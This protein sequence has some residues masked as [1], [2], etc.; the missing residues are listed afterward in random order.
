[1]GELLRSRQRHY[2]SSWVHALPDGLGFAG[3]EN[4]RA[5][6]FFL[7]EVAPMENPG[8]ESR[9]LDS[10]GCS[11]LNSNTAGLDMP[12]AIDVGDSRL[13]KI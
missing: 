1:M 6:A 13:R 5:E 10:R 12:P 9:D 11:V 8:K 7:A 2:A 3:D 4:N